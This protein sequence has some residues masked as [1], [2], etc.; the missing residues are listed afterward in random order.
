MRRHLVVQRMALFRHKGVPKYEPADSVG[1]FLGKA[2]NYRAA[3]GM[4]NEDKILTSAF[5]IC[6][7]RSC[8]C[9]A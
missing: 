1:D 3:V 5:T 7:T 6:V 9:W 2:G 8:I 4:A